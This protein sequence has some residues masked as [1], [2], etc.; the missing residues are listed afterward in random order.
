[1]VAKLNRPNV[2]LTKI[3]HFANFKTLNSVYHAIFGSPLNYSLLIWIQNAKLVKR[4]LVLR[5]KSLRIKHF[6]NRNIHTTTVLHTSLLKLPYKIFPENWVRI[7]NNF[8]RVLPKS[9]T[10]TQ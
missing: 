6:L 1:M 10:Q 5:K 7:C 8:N 9:F 2:V 3:R 4:L